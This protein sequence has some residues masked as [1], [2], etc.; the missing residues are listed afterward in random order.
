MAE[1][2]AHECDKIMTEAEYRKNLV[3]KR[4]TAPGGKT[5]PEADYRKSQDGG[6]KLKPPVR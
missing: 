5:I 6:V 2:I 3:K 4:K 1:K